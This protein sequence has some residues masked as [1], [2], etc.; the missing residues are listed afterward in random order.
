[1]IPM[2]FNQTYWARVEVDLANMP[3]DACLRK[4]FQI[5]IIIIET[6]SEEHIYKKNIVKLFLLNCLFILLITF[7]NI[8]N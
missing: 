8:F 2:N 7:F 4:R 1:M 3:V 5:I 6:K